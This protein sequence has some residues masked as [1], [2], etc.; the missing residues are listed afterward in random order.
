MT[1]EPE[2]SIIYGSDLGD[3]PEVKTTFRF[4]GV[5]RYLKLVGSDAYYKSTGRNKVVSLVIHRIL[6]PDKES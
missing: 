2:R 6:Y 4:L 3:G 5:L 1:E